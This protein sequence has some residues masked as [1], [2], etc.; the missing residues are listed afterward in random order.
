M[1]SRA[2]PQ[3]RSSL[4][5]Q[6]HYATKVR[7]VSQRAERHSALRVEILS[8]YA[9]T[10]RVYGADKVW[11]KLNREAIRVARCTVERLLRQLGI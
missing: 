1:V 7:A 10:R 9:E 5:P 6:T 8:V 11:A 3:E 2:D 4:P